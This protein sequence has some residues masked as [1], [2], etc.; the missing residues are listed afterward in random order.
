M[1]AAA[2]VPTAWLTARQVSELSERVGDPP[3]H[4]RRRERAYEEFLELPLE[5]NPLYRK[6]GYFG[7][8]DLTG[9]DPTAAG[10]AVALP[11]VPADTVR[12][13]HDAAGTRAELTPEATAA[14]VRFEGLA[15]VLA[16]DV[17]GRVE[18][19]PASGTAPDRLSA[20]GETLVNRGYRLT[21]PPHLT[22]PVRVQDLT[23]LSRPKEAISVLRDLRVGPE[24][25]LL[26]SEE[27]YS[28]GISETQRLVAST[29]NLRVGDGARAAYVGVHAPD[30][31]AVGL[32]Q[33]HA[34]AGANARVG[35]VW[36]GFGGFRTRSRNVSVLEGQGS[37]VEDLQTFFGSGHQSY[38]SAVQM[39]HLGTDTHGQSITRGLF[40]DESRG[41]SRGLVRIEKDARRTLSF[42]S[43]HAMLL[44][45]GAR[46]D[47]IPIL[48]ILCR[49]VKATHSS[50]VAPVDPEKVFYLETRGLPQP[51]AI[52][53]LGEG[54][55]AHVL[56]RAP[57]GQLRE[58]LYPVLETRWDHREVVWGADG[59]PALERLQFA[60][61]VAETDWRFDAKL[62]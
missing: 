24:S 37:D 23:I 46:S 31:Q 58:M 2:P 12:I 35:W 21:V 44:S 50:S 40:Q 10:A 59:F 19:S 25:R 61:D 27:V 13:V 49:D 22:T 54:F 36:A 14:G 52:R 1:V 30:S 41:M 18:F 9:I 38:D 55:L 29:T 45:K 26:M 32:Y 3:T 39:T 57:I 62:R 20:L 43:E 48:E 15:T 7:G 53:M 33:R 6:Y 56:A 60:E 4:A 51:E 42:L 17:R 28:T 8:V 34:T 16:E 5:P 11:P 47:T